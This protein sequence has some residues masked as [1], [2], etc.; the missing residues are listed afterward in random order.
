MNNKFNK[1][2]LF[3]VLN[4][5]CI[6]NFLFSMQEIPV[7]EQQ[8]GIQEDQR[9]QSTDDRPT[10]SQFHLENKVYEKSNFSG[11]F[12]AWIEK[13]SE[14]INKVLQKERELQDT[15]YVFYTGQNIKHYFIQNLITLLC[16]VLGEEKNL[17][18]NPDE[19][20]FLRVPEYSSEIKN[21][22]DFFS[23]I[24][25]NCINDTNK[26]I[27]KILLSSNLAL[28]GGFSELASCAFSYFI[29]NKSYSDCGYYYN[30]LLIDIIKSLRSLFNLNISDQTIVEFA[31]ILNSN[32]SELSANNGCLVQIFIPKNKVND[33]VYISH[34]LGAP[35]RD[36]QS[37]IM[38]TRDYI[39][40]YY[41]DLNSNSI[42]YDNVQA[43]I[44]FT[45][46]I[47]LNPNSGVKIYRYL[48]ENP[49]SNKFAEVNN[50]FKEIFEALVKSKN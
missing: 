41:Q 14:L 11:L 33:C 23:K 24:N 15:D 13:H 50:I 30:Y 22:N 12:E 34:E 17:N 5:A 19:F 42:N 25:F 38:N 16:C 27:S 20:S 4:F 46:D 48:G 49:N 40:N 9:G 39:E 31:Y 1:I 10:I 18:C 35:V 44:L 43:R 45:N 21:L 8:F 2:F 3:L 37:N 7:I 26:E 6:N 32:L 29:S 36:E 28:L 47:M